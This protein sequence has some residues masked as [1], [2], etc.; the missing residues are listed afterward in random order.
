MIESS[1]VKV[2]AAR[3][4]IPGEELLISYS[5]KDVPMT[6]TQLMAQYGIALARNDYES[7]RL[8]LGLSTLPR[9]EL[10]QHRDH[11]IKSNQLETEAT[12]RMNG[13]IPPGFL[14]ALRAK[15]L[16]AQDFRHLAQFEYRF[17]PENGYFSLQNELRVH[18]QLLGSIETLLT[19]PTTLQQDVAKLVPQPDKQQEQEQEQTQHVVDKA[20]DE[21]Q[22]LAYRVAL[23]RVLHVIILRSF[24]LV[25]DLF[26]D[27][28]KRWHSDIQALE[29]KLEEATVGSTS[30]DAAE[31]TKDAK[32][33]NAEQV[34]ELRKQLVTWRDNMATWSKEMGEWDERW[35][36]WV[37]EA[38]E[39][40]WLEFNQNSS[41]AGDKN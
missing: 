1:V 4:L 24:Q 36:A 37:A 2:I 35:Q 18:L 23:K 30:P 33:D 17:K 34:A 7:I 29:T 13:V 26:M 31:A 21:Y 16:T 38:V 25:R 28:S 5:G 19:H 14:Q 40:R 11:V 12:I 41:N 27:L 15:E 22:I 9:D 10:S 39:P 32:F 8:D 20:S 6:N 3:D